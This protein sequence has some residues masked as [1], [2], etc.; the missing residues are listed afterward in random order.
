MFIVDLSHPRDSATRLNDSILEPQ[1]GNRCAQLSL[2]QP[3][4]SH[5]PISDNNLYATEKFAVLCRLQI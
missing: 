5:K 1:N 4:F 3:T 2:N